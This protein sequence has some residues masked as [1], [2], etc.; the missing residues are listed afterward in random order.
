M[1]VTYNWLKDF[2]EI[3]IPAKALAEK[4]TM[5]GLEVTS[6]EEKE[7]D[8]VLEIEVTSNRPDW[9]SVIGIAREVAAITNKKFNVKS[10]MF[11][12][13][14]NIKHSTL[15]IKQLSIEIQNKKDCPLYTARIIK[16]V[17]VGPSPGWLRKRLE[18]IGCHSINNVVDITNYILFTYGEPLHA[19]DLDKFAQGAINVRRAKSGEKIVTIDG[20]ERAL[21]PDI[22]VIADDKKPVAV[23]GV[24][25]SKDTEVAESTRNIL[26]EAASFNPIVVR[27]G[28]Q[29]LGIQSDSSYRFERGVNLEL[30]DEASSRAAELI[31]G[32]AGGNCI[33]AKSSGLARS[34]K[35]IV[36]LDPQAINKTL[37]ANIPA[38]KIREILNSL[39]FKIKTKTKNQLSVKAP[40]YR[41]DVN[42][43]VD[44][45]EE[46]A[47]I[48]G[49]ENI[50]QTLPAVRPQAAINDARDIISL[51]KGILAGLGLNEVIT[52]G[53]MDKDL[54]RDFGMYDGRE[55]IEVLNPLSNE[56]EILRPGLIPSLA[57]CVSRN[58]NQ[59]QDYVNIFEVAKVFYP[60]GS[61]LKEELKL[62]IALSGKKSLLLQEGLIEDQSGLLHLKGILE[63]FLG[64]LGVKEHDFIVENNG[65][66]VSLSVDRENIGLLAKI[67]K[68][69]LDKLGIKNKDVFLAELS[70]DRLLFY[71]NLNKKFSHLPVYP[72]IS[73]DI[74]LILK[75]EILAGELLKATKE[76]GKPLL[77][78]ARVTDYYK[79]RQIPAGFKGLTISCLYRSNER[80]LTE[81]EI[82]PTHSLICKILID[83][84]GAQIRSCPPAPST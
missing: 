7:G 63:V 37:G 58:L 30:V 18:L 64:R 22:L 42:E 56:Q 41:S 2:V 6:L 39:G 13:K 14:R 34:K 54:L 36:S 46:I 5:A 12:A 20:Q 11:N 67:E 80:T 16:G 33:L 32:L 53:L 70:L 47:R 62:G 74:S 8:F 76:A 82:N 1:K 3:K 77:E 71:V 35:K 79:G 31:E 45:I 51:A 4:L 44:L 55:V 17:K 83:S 38:S 68:A 28:R 25:G 72:A 81:A 52:Y 19:F 27:R 69:V 21:N 73:R 48:Y 9:L 60:A 23:A 43:G 84:F 66:A 40:G 24:M 50:A 57:S 49:Y 15:N 65:L 75:N 61:S 26:L 10:L 59:K 78:E 29:A